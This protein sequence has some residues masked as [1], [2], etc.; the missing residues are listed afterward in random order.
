MCSHSLCSRRLKASAGEWIQKT[1]AI[2]SNYVL[3]L[4][5]LWFLRMA[6]MLTKERAV[7]LLNRCTARLVRSSDI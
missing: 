4:Y 3:H 7:R 6:S 1:G 5:Q 2:F